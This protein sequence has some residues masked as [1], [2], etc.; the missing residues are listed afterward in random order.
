MLFLVYS[1]L[2]NEHVKVKR[3][4]ITKVK[5]IIYAFATTHENGNDHI[6]YDFQVSLLDMLF[7]SKGTISI[8]VDR[9]YEL[10]NFFVPNISSN[11]KIF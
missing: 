5:Y 8:K 1:I 6:S 2:H 10:N 11:Q 9:E 7:K 4:E 3:D